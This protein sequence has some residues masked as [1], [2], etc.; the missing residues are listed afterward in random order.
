M[1]KIYILLILLFTGC[2]IFDKEEPIPS[3]VYIDAADL[4]VASDGSQG[5]NT[6]EIIDAHVFANENF[7]GTIELPGLAAILEEGPTRITIGG[8]IRNNGIF[9][10]RIIYPY[11]EFT[12]INLDLTPGVVTPITEDS[13]ITFQYPDVA[14]FLFE[15]FEG[16]GNIWEPSVDGGI[17]IVNSSEDVQEGS[18]TASGK[19]LLTDE[20]PL[21]QVYSQEPEWDLSPITPGRAVYLELDY[22]GNNP[23]EIGIRTRTPFDQQ[24]FAL[25]LNPTDDWTKIYVELTDEIGEGQTN[26]FQVY[27]QAQKFDTGDAIIYI[28]NLKLLYIDF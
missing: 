6:N 19:I 26:D 24:I 17:A 9:S 21:L 8:G 11:Y 4:I 18:G 3:F 1:R 5:P 2:D 25:G 20:F 10:D 28:D 7:V 27:L 13:T 16:I 22:K 12:T 14:E 15:G 23:L